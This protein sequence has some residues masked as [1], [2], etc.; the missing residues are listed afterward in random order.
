M[1]FDRSAAVFADPAIEPANM[2]FALGA[3]SRVERPRMRA[4]AP[5]ADL[6]FDCQNLRFTSVED[7]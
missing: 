4:V 2:T 7:P 1:I 6:S 3:D 5:T